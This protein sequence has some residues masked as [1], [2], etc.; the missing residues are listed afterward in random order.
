[1]LATASTGGVGVGWVP[2]A[3]SGLERKRLAAALSRAQRKAAQRID[4]LERQQ[5]QIASTDEL[6]RTADL[7]LAYGHLAPR[8]AT[9][10]MVPHPDEQAEQLRIALDPA[11][12]VHAQAEKLY[13]KARKL[14]DAAAISSARLDETRQQHAQLE[15]LAG[16][17]DATADGDLA[18]LADELTAAG[19]LAAPRQETT[20]D[21]KITGGENFRRFESAEGYP[22][23]VGR[24]NRQNDRLT[25]RVARGNDLWLHVGQGQSGSHVVVRLPR[26]KTASLETMLDAATLAVHF[27]RARGNPNCEVIYTQAKH[28]RK[29]KGLPPGSVIPSRTRSI[30]VRHE[31][32]R[33]TRL[34]DSAS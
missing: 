23:F 8:G 27:S 33:L 21:R 17:L 3:A 24:N 31:A 4:G 30:T 22:I 18:A 19:V 1:M 13:K 7:M 14:T 9:E 2:T 28:V 11:Q 20:K 5:E 6:R 16:K 15:A 34:L 26:G 29:P 32:A 25:T 12:S 10:L